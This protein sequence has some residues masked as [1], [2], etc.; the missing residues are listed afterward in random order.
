MIQSPLTL[1]HR[2]LDQLVGA[3]QVG[4]IEENGTTV[5]DGLGTA[6]A[7]LRRSKNP[8]KVVILISDGESTRANEMEPLAAKD[9]AVKLGV[10]V[11]T[12]LMGDLKA[13]RRFDHVYGVDPELLQEIARDT[14]GQYFNAGDDRGLEESF[15]QIR[16]QLAKSAA[17]VTVTSEK[18]DLFPFCLWLAIALLGLE[19]I[20]R[21]TRWRTFP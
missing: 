3:L 8:S 14:G 1:D 9:L 16:D 6:L 12:V 17:I 4:D 13:A 21:N 20:M 11:F 10:R 15:S 2:A 19:T 5:G 7:L 18:V